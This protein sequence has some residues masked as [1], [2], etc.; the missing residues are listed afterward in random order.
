MAAGDLT[1][2]A[3]VKLMLGIDAVETSADTILGML[4]SSQSAFFLQQID[5]PLA[6][7]SY[8]ETLDGHS[9]RIRM[10]LGMG[11]SSF[12]NGGG[13][14]FRGGG[15]ALTLLNMPVVSITSMMIDGSPV[16]QGSGANTPAQVD[17][18]TLNGARIELLGF[19]YAFTPGI[20]NV[21]IVYTA[22]YA[23]VPSDVEQAVF[24]LV[25]YRYKERDHRGQRSK[26]M[27]GQTVYFQADG[28]P[29]SVQ[30][31]IDQYKRLKF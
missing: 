2:L 14:W 21:V 13:G 20:Q 3:R 19:T 18:W 10:R 30:T 4:I 6:L 22:G 17:G 26:D 9:D 31:T 23:A 15:Y 16:P 24:E 7:A 25:D 5:R 11:P 27:S 12:A 1:T 8:T 28:V 29:P